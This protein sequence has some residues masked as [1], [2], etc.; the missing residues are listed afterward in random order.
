MAA[1]NAIETRERLLAAAADEFAAKGIAGARVDQIAALAGV[2]KRM[3]YYYFGSKEQLF[4]EVQ[5]V[6]LGERVAVAESMTGDRGERSAARQAHH[7]DDPDYVRMLVW[8]ALEDSDHD[9]IEG[10]EYRS[11]TFAS[12]VDSVAAAQAAGE[13][14]AEFDPAQWVLS[15][16]ALTVFPVAFP[17]LTRLICGLDVTDPEFLERR[18]EFLRNLYRRLDL[19][20]ST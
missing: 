8:E 18:Q 1:R 15:E 19:P 16:L 4:R 9:A 5:R 2:N 17:Q 7:I 20:A 12:W 11:Q 6:K 14:P 10:E 13:I 3:L